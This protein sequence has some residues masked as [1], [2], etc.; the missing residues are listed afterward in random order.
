[1]T[2]TAPPEPAD[3]TLVALL[4]LTATAERLLAGL[5]DVELPDH[6]RSLASELETAAVVSWATLGPERRMAGTRG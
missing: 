5:R 2:G 3:R 6:V 1:M 4:K